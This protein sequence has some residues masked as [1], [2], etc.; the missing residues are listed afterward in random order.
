MLLAVARSG[1]G[2]ALS[3]GAPTKQLWLQ[4]NDDDGDHHAESHQGNRLFLPG[5]DP[6]CSSPAT[7]WLHKS[8]HP[9]RITGLQC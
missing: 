4:R 6:D 8:V 5:V 9:S 3:D 7:W 1:R 2:S